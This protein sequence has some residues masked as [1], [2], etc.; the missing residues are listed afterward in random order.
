MNFRRDTIRK[1]NPDKSNVEHTKMIA[2]E[3]NHM[4]EELKK[5]YLQ[6]AEVDKER[7]NNNQYHFKSCVTK[8]TLFFIQI[9]T[10]NK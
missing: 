1:E 6:A 2:D 4:S 7:Y 3:W 8:L 5:P 9:D 10:I